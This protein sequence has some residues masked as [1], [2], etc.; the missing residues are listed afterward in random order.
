MILANRASHDL[1]ERVVVR[2][3]SIEMRMELAMVNLQLRPSG[4]L[5][6]FET[7]PAGRLYSAAESSDRQ[8]QLS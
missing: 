2:R 5:A 7:A 4:Q 1:K 3:L 6:G 8:V